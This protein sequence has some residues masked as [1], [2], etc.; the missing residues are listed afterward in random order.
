MKHEER[1]KAILSLA[2]WIEMEK[3][4]VVR[5]LPNKFIIDI[6]RAISHAQAIFLVSRGVAQELADAAFGVAH[7]RY[8]KGLIA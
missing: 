3:L 8:L 2:A 7:E 6:E 1:Q 5:T 4:G